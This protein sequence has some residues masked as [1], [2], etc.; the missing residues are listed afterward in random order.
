MI[1]YENFRLKRSI[2]LICSQL[3]MDLYYEKQ[4]NTEKNQHININ[5]PTKRLSTIRRNIF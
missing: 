1:L 2:K 5:V 3:T 4:D